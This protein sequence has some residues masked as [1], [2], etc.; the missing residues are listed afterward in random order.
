MDA[1]SSASFLHL[2]TCWNIKLSCSMA[3]LSSP[4]SCI[5]C[6]SSA[7]AAGRQKE[8]CSTRQPAHRC[9]RA[10]K[11][12]LDRSTAPVRRNRHKMISNNRL[13]GIVGVFDLESEES[14]HRLVGRAPNILGK[15]L[16]A[17][18][19]GLVQGCWRVKRAEE[20]RQA[21]AG[22]ACHAA[23][24]RARP[25]LLTSST[26]QA[27]SL[28]SRWHADASSQLTSC[29]QPPCWLPQTAGQ[30]S[31]ATGRNG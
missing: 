2:H 6:R 7:T 3:A 9:G 13:T 20:K 31:S 4:C 8:P 22:G 18:W 17:A 28:L 29:V 11:E 23:H 10:V 14:G 12:A 21:Y 25:Q 30:G 24:V 5:A 19:V 15:L 27:D 16:Q 1:L 26:T